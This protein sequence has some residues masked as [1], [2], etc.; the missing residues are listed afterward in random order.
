MLEAFITAFI[1]YFV[2]IDPVGNAPIFLAVTQHQDRARKLRTALEG[3]AVATAIMLFFAL[4]GGWILAYLNISE[5]AFRIAGGIILFLVALDMLA[6]KRQQ[7]KREAST[8]DDASVE[9]DNVAIYPLAIPLLAGPSAIMSV[10]VVTSGFASGG[11]GAVLTGYAA[12]LAVMVAT[13]TILG[14]TVLA[15]GWMNEKIT[16]VFSRITAI[17]LAGLSVQYIIDG[18]ATIGLITRS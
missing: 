8:G 2:V 1:I 13:G 17:I 9:A 7:R 10:I 12:L 18:L 15:E 14:L 6:A 3:T 4:C 11:F 5:A 16:M